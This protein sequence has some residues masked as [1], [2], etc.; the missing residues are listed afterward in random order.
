[1]CII[2]GAK[3]AVK[4]VRPHYTDIDYA[5]RTDKLL[6]K[7]G[8]DH[9]YYE[10]EYGH[11]LFRGKRFLVEYLKL[12]A[13]LRRDPCY[14]HI[15]LA[16]PNGYS[17]MWLSPVEH[18]RW[19]SLNESAEGTIQVD[20]LL[21]NGA[22]EFDEWRLKQTT[23]MRPGAAIEATS[24]GDNTIAVTAR[25][26]ALFTVWLH[27]RMID[28][29]KPVKVVVNDKTRFDARVKPSL[30]TALES[31]E[32]RGDWGLVYPVRVEISVAE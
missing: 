25:N 7:L 12:C 3:D 13:G 23:A 14:P 6:T 24:R 26:V 10:H 21:G 19:L 18:N 9:T 11:D 27:P 1:L 4:G 5:R 31:Y 2:H 29:N 30:V 22:N 15:A 32:R 20:E 16:S 8:L 28:V 17:P